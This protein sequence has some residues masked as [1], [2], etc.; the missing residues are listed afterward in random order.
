M[1]EDRIEYSNLRTMTLFS[2]DEKMETY[3][4]SFEGEKRE[5]PGYGYAFLFGTRNFEYDETQIGLAIV[6]NKVVIKSASELLKE[7]LYE[8]EARVRGLPNSMGS[9]E[10]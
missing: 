6:N 2:P 9:P 7:G 5:L 10:N 3:E 8:L 4:G 1:P